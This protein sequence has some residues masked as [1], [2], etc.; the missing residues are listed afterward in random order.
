MRGRAKLVSRA[1]STTLDRLDEVT[2]ELRRRRPGTSRYERA[3][4]EAERLN[5]DVIELTA[6]LNALRQDGA[7]PDGF[8]VAPVKA[9]P[10]R[11][12]VLAVR[13]RR[14]AVPATRAPTA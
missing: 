10:R 12:S 9:R 3:L 11:N 6:E 8:V 2:R 14:A 5:A 1:L 13:E 7:T 4:A